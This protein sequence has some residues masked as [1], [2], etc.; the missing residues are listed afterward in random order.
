M[1][2]KLMPM[3]LRSAPPRP[4]PVL[5]RKR[6]HDTAVACVWLLVAGGLAVAAEL[7]HVRDA[8]GTDTVWFYAATFF[9]VTF[10]TML[11]QGLRK[12]GLPGWTRLLVVL[13]VS[14]GLAG[15]VY[16]MPSSPFAVAPPWAELLG[17]AS[18]VVAVA[19]LVAYGPRRQRRAHWLR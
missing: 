18:I 11:S 10:F 14:G 17:V 4:Y 6:V 8:R 3:P 1:N 19:G 9:V 12:V 5:R 7:T 15:A 2:R 13:L 16:T